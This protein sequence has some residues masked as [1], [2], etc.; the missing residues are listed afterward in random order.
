[1]DMKDFI[2]QTFEQI[3]EGIKA[4][5][6]QAEASGAQINPPLSSISRSD[7]A[8]IGFA[9][10]KNDAT[11]TIV[12]F[13]VGVNVGGKGKNVQINIGTNYA[14]ASGQGSSQVQGVPEHRVRFKI[15]LSLP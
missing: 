12:D 4:A 13:D 5:Q 9:M 10:A 3:I 6:Q 8:Q 14:N 1:M 2:T 15:P 11:V 7:A